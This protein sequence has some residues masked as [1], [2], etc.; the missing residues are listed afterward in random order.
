V[1]PVPNESKIRKEENKS[2]QMNQQVIQIEESNRDA[3]CQ[4][5]RQ[6]LGLGIARGVSKH[7][8]KLIYVRVAALNASAP[9]SRFLNSTVQSSRKALVS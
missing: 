2:I 7:W 4:I 6:T 1:L 9:S 5:P 3:S 8:V